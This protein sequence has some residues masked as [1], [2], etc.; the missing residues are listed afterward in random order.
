LI[1]NSHKNSVFYVFT[2]ACHFQRYTFYTVEKG[3]PIVR[4]N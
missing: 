1:L 2:N 3:N 4:S